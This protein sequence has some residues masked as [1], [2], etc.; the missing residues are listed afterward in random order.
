MWEQ[1]VNILYIYI[2]IW[3]SVLHIWPFDCIG[4]PV[5]S[6][7]HRVFLPHLLGP[8]WAIC[9]AGGPQPF[10]VQSRFW[11][12][13]TAE[14]TCVSS[15]SL[16][17]L[18]DPGRLDSFPKWSFYVDGSAPFGESW[19][20]TWTRAPFLQAASPPVPSQA[21]KIDERFTRVFP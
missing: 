18:R 3:Q 21:R 20:F 10:S 16:G 4:S 13:P 2:Y 19:C 11:R 7:A 6:Q 17:L 9:V 12:H 5:D 8:C 1:L 14:K 15:W